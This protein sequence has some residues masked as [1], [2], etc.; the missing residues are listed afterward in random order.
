MGNGLG[1]H[2]FR[3]EAGNTLAPFF[4]LHIDL[5]SRSFAAAPEMVTVRG[6]H[7]LDGIG[8]N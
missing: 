3:G 6:V 8:K 5:M 4:D 1:L 7:L 2:V